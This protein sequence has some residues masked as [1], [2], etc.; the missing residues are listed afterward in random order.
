MGKRREIYLAKVRR[1]SET[2]ANTVLGGNPCRPGPCAI[3][4]RPFGPS[5]PICKGYVHGLGLV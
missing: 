1:T 3:R 4:E 2:V 5:F